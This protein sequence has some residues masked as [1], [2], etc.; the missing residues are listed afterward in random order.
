MRTRVMTSRRK[1]H[2]K[3]ASQ[4][5]M[6]PLIPKNQRWSPQW[7]IPLS[8][9]ARHKERTGNEYLPANSEPPNFLKEMGS[10]AGDSGGDDDEGVGLHA[11]VVVI[12]G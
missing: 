8:G 10:S 2:L 5:T 4:D 12:H 1:Q 7:A 3:L 9:A 11:L 6:R